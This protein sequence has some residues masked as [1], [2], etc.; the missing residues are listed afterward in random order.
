MKFLK[1]VEGSK[2]ANEFPRII[3]NESEK[4]YSFREFLDT[5]TGFIGDK[6]DEVRGM[7]LNNIFKSPEPLKKIVEERQEEKVVLKLNKK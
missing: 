4:K 2:D 1:P 3:K 7:P 6:K 5:S